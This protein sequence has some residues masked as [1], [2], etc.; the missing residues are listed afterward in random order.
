M[1]ERPLWENAPIVGRVD[2]PVSRKVTGQEADIRQTGA[3]TAKTVVDT[4]RT[5]VLTPLEVEEKRETVRGK[6]RENALP[7]LT[8]G[9]AKAD[10]A[11]GKDYASWV[12]EG[13]A[14]G[15]RAKLRRIAAL[16]KELL[17]PASPD[18][19]SGPLI[20]RAPE[21]VRQGLNE[22]GLTLENDARA[23]VTA[24]LRQ[25]LGA[26]FTEKEGERIFN[27]S[28]NPR[29]SEEA[30]AHN[31][32]RIMGEN[33]SNA[34]GRIAAASY[35]EKNGTLQ[36]FTQDKIADEYA[37]LTAEA[38]TDAAGDRFTPEQEQ[39]LRAFAESPGF[40]PEGYAELGKRFVVDLGREPD[41]AFLA[42]MKQAGEDI[43]AQKA[44]GEGFGPGVQYRPSPAQEQPGDAEPPLTGMDRALDVAGGAVKNF[45]PDLGG[46]LWDSAKGMWD[47]AGEGP[48]GEAGKYAAPAMSAAMGAGNAIST[49]GQSA[50]AK[51]GIGNASPQLADAVGKMYADRYG[52]PDKALNTLRDNPAEMLMDIA[53][54]FTGGELAAPRI[55]AQMGKVERLA[56]SAAKVAEMGAASGKA[57]RAVDPLL[58]TGKG[59]ALAAKYIP[60]G[61]K[62]A[63]HTLAVK[64]PAEV[65]GLPS[66]YGGEN[67]RTA[68]GIGRERSMQGATPRTEAFTGNMTGKAP[69]E[70]IVTQLEAGVQRMRD[71]ASERYAADM[72]GV[73][74][75]KTVLGFEGIDA[76]LEALKGRAY[77]KDQVR[78]P[79]AAR[80]YGDIQ[81]LVEEW[82][83][84]PADE[85]HTPEGMDAL[86]QRIGGVE[87]KYQTENDRA[88]ASIAA[89]VRKA[90]TA[91]ITQQA[92][93][94]AAAMKNYSDAKDMLLNIRNTLDSGK[95][96]TDA[97]IRRLQGVLKRDDP[98][99][100]GKLLE[101]VDQAP[102]HH[103]RESLAGRAGESIRPERYRAAA[104]GV[105]GAAS[106]P[107]E[108]L[109][110]GAGPAAAALS[111]SIPH[112]AAAMAM[113]S[114]RVVSG[115]A[116]GAGRAAGLAELA[117]RGGYDAYGASGVGRLGLNALATGERAKETL[118]ED[119]AL[120]APDLSMLKSRYGA[121]GGGQNEIVVADRPGA[122]DPLAA[123]DLPALQER[124][125]QAAPS[126]P[127]AP[128]GSDL[129]AGYSIDP[130]TREIILPDGTR[131]ADPAM[132]NPVTGR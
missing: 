13:G 53:S 106:L 50:L 72:E 112:Y 131:I 37:R 119:Y 113:M 11:W 69:V 82:K 14:E 81:S 36:G 10:E 83:G 42:G 35:Y 9:Q 98:G 17:D 108:A 123:P 41:E 129:P 73:K 88:A 34:A 132:V 91:E 55:A 38:K 16:Q 30:N 121:A 97:T 111:G 61:A 95:G 12:N 1:A 22:R 124:Y 99:Y 94:Y 86:K 33:L 109:F 76:E 63:L 75:D 110:A 84:L 27:Q 67:I 120:P 92:P 122:V 126:A 28:F 31:L 128:G 85:F 20:G 74:A 49:L 103:L 40:T 3:S 62:D 7:N 51:I 107:F 58:L 68:A 26:Q 102:D 29:L 104:A 115:G 65:A 56:G 100:A 87:G 4:N 78:D 127:A 2:D 48:A 130:V 18:T 80:A 54:V 57:A 125:P 70:D 52:S 77:F 101:E 66:G 5:T 59:A 43:V 64:Y 46:V 117:A 24:T 15:L 105:L 60:Q 19:L 23:L 44:R 89:G 90:V 21:I 116:Y 32:K 71:A 79:A 39:A 96:R 25:I 47:L 114:P 93:T 6:A 118:A 45:I 8:P